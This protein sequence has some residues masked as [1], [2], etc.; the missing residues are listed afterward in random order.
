M[1]LKWTKSRMNGKRAKQEWNREEDEEDEEDGSIRRN[2]RN[3]EKE[4][5]KEREINLNEIYHLKSRCMPLLYVFTQHHFASTARQ[6][7]TIVYILES[8]EPLPWLQTI[9]S[10]SSGFWGEER[11]VINNSCANIFMIYEKKERKREWEK[12]R[13]K[14]FEEQSREEKASSFLQKQIDCKLFIVFPR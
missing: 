8:T 10:W 2:R 3:E 7:L 9:E 14:E 5:K 4:R 11:S 6:T 13:K 12:E 1:R